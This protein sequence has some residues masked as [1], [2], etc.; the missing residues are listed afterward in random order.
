M[1][2]LASLYRVQSEV[3][4][5]RRL[6][7]PDE[8]LQ[9]LASLASPL[10]EAVLHTRRAID[11]AKAAHEQLRSV[12]QTLLRR[13]IE[14]ASRKADVQGEGQN[15]NRSAVSSLVA[16]LRRELTARKF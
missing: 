7:L 1:A 3:A 2:D 10:E 13:F 4:V 8:P 15:C 14:L 11:A 5:A 6:A 12:D 9:A 16:E